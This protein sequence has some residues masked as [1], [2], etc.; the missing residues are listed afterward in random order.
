MGDRSD[1]ASS[2]AHAFWLSIARASARVTARRWRG[3]RF[4][5]YHSVASAGELSAP[6]R[7]SLVVSV[8]GFRNHLAWVRRSGYVVVAMAEARRLLHSGDAARGQFVCLTF[9]D[10]KLDNFAVAW[11]VLRAAGHSAHFFVNSAMV[12]QSATWMDAD[13]VRTIVR[14]GGSIGSH[15]DHHVDLTRLGEPELR[16]ELVESRRALEALTGG[17]IDTHAY[18]YGAY[19]PR[20][21]RATEAAGYAVAF[22]VSTGAVRAIGPH[23]RFA[24][25]RNA[26]RTGADNPDNYAIIRGGFDFTRLYSDA[27][28]RWKTAVARPR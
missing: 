21:V 27:R 23:N 2:P 9:D 8:D 24:I 4:L 19:D 26:I 1:V 10:G 28:R 18:P 20:V 22:K 25:P 7:A 17:P 5:C 15:A 16:S 12:G 14:E 3:V 11:P 13:A 6:A